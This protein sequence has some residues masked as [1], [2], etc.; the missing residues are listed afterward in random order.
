MLKIK[1]F[2]RRLGMNIRAVRTNRDKPLSQKKLGLMVGLTQG[3]IGHIELGR[4]IPSTYVLYKIAT[5]LN[6]SIDSLVN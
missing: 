4:K 1:T 2:A 3:H 6:V 5:K